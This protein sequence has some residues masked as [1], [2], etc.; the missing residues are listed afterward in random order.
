MRLTSGLGALSWNWIRPILAF[1]MRVGPPAEVTTFWFRTTPLSM[2]S[3]SSI[4]PPT[5]FHDADVAKVDVGGGGSD[6]ARDGFDGDGREGGR[7]L[8]DD[9]CSTALTYI[10]S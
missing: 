10:L 7:V 1:S 8:R 2:S 3:V 9:L 4:V 6:E 5:F